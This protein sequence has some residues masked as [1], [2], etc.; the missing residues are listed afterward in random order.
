MGRKGTETKEMKGV[1]GV[2]EE[3][4]ERYCIMCEY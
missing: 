2:G 4:M 3:E 1:G